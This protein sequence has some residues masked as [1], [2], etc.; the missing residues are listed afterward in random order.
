MPDLILTAVF[1]FKNKLISEMMR[2]YSGHSNKLKENK[3]L[4]IFEGLNF[5]LGHLG[6]QMGG[7]RAC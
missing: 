2:A 1:T 7:L 5:H 4:F 6:E 3:V